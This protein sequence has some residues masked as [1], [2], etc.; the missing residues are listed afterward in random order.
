MNKI[1]NY[2]KEN[3]L[4]NKIDFANV[5]ISDTIFDESIELLES[6]NISSSTTYIKYSQIIK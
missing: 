3:I 2:L 4:N 1:T 6:L 5:V